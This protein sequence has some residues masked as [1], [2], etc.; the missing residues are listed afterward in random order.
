M[1]K[2]VFS[3]RCETE[4]FQ[5]V[6]SLDAFLPFENFPEHLDKVAF[7]CA[8]RI[9]PDFWRDKASAF[10]CLELS[11]RFNNATVHCVTSECK[12]GRQD[13]ELLIDSRNDPK[14]VVQLLQESK[15]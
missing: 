13:I 12:L 11:A 2:Y 1:H 8:L 10:D 4:N 9:Q 14:G 15:I 5:P 3:V 7:K 6:F